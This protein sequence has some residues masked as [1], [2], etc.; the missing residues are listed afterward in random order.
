MP[1]A[2]DQRAAQRRLHNAMLAAD[3]E[4]V[5]LLVLGNDHDACI[6]AQAA[7]ALDRQIAA[8]AFDGLRAQR[9]LVDVH[10]DLVV[11]RGRRALR[12]LAAQVRPRH[13][14]QRIGLARMQ[15]LL[16]IRPGRIT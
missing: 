4:R 5:A 7:H 15:R 14:D 11:I 8:R 1:V 10:H 2:S 3:V 13:I 6:A 16:V 12:R 9:R